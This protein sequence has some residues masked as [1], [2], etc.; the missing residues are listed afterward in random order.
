[1]A[2]AADGE[3]EF[4][5]VDQRLSES[6]KFSLYKDLKE[7]RSLW[8][9]SY[10]PSKNKHQNKLPK[11]K[12]IEELSQKHNLSPGYLKPATDSCCKNFAGK[13]NKKTK[14]R[15]EV[16]MEVLRHVKLY[17]RRRSSFA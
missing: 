5:A 1:M 7:Y 17:E 2:D 9:T 11:E 13:G 14:W 12:G 4:E 15:P 8:D 10:V 3:D 6:Q 16:E